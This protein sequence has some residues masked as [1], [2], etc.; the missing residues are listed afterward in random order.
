MEVGIGGEYDSTNL[1]DKPVV[2]GV[3]ALGFDHTNILGNTIE[4][5]AWNK[6]GIFK[7][8]VVVGVVV[9]VVVVVVVVVAAAVVV[10]VVVVV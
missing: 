5:I 6:A 9:E 10:A 2:C 1:F 8:I 7:V 4:E 3:T